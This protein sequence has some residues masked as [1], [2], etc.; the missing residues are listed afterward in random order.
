[1]S[2]QEHR[3]IYIISMNIMYTQDITQEIKHHAKPFA[4]CFEHPVFQ[5][6]QK[7]ATLKTIHVISNPLSN[8]SQDRSDLS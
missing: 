5:G 3:L 1:M 2:E 6:Q 4:C 7:P 8:V